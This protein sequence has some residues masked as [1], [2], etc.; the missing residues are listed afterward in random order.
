MNRTRKTRLRFFAFAVE[1]V[2]EARLVMSAI[3][4]QIATRPVA[5]IAGARENSHTLAE[6][7]L[8]GA[9]RPPGRPNV[10]HATRS[11]VA[12]IAP[13]YRRWSW[14]ANT[15]WYVPTANLTAILNNVSTGHVAPVSDQT[16]FQVK[17]YQGGY[18]WGNVVTQLGSSTA[19]QSNLVG[20]VTPQGKVQLTFAPTS[21][22]SSSSPSITQGFGTM[23]RKRGQWAMAN[24][25]FTA[26]NETMQIGHWAYM[27]QTHPGLPSW[28]SLP[29]SGESVPEFL[30]Q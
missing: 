22:S 2:L 21:S 16:V 20:S 3:G 1:S 8:S 28:N 26:P 23:E 19:V 10:Q 25:M 4:A 29:G 12:P 15:Y 13:T 30:S 7:R 11:V 6:H 27:L 14:L 17:G 18:F 24:Q 5:T 9:A